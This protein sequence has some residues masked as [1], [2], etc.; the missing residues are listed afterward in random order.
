M[1]DGAE[2]I[3]DSAEE[4]ENTCN[5]QALNAFA[6]QKIYTLTAIV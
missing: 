3:F 2:V 4:K 5:N 1:V 6:L